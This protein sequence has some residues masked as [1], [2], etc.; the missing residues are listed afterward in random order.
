LAL[1]LRLVQ[2]GRGV[3]DDP[4]SQRRVDRQRAKDAGGSRP[5]VRR[6]RVWI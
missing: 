4:A 1:W 3:G 2:R 6:R 5:R